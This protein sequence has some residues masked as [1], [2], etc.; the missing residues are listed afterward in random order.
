VP[1]LGAKLC[2]GCEIPS[3]ISIFFADG[4]FS[5]I[6]DVVGGPDDEETIRMDPPE[7]YIFQ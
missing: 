5:F 1:R 2:H 3:T 6:D 7:H 4:L